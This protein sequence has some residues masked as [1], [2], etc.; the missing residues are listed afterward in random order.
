MGTIKILH[1]L[2]RSLHLSITLLVMGGCVQLG[3]PVISE[4]SQAAKPPRPSNQ[5]VLRPT[6][7]TK[8]PPVITQ[9]PSVIPKVV[10]PAAQP[11]PKAARTAPATTT[12]TVGAG[13]TLY[14]IAW[15]FQL[16][17]RS[18]AQANNIPPPYTIYPGQTLSLTAAPRTPWQRTDQKAD[19]KT[20]QKTDQKLIEQARTT[21]VPKPV[22]EP[23]PVTALPPGPGAAATGG[24]T[25]KPQVGP[26]LWP[27][28]TRPT[29][30]FSRASKGM[31]FTLNGRTPVR[32]ASSGEVVY[33]GSGIGG[34]ER[35]VIVKHNQN[36][37]SAYSLNGEIMVREQQQVKAGAKLADIRNTGRASQVL[38]FELRRN[39]QPINPREKLP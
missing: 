27:V 23:E 35:L 29:R 32:A 19:H 18:L 25:G 15:R 24:V 2:S 36:L 26:W 38:H 8:P 20:V 6:R 30:E 11:A 39:G 12:Y 22:A 33:A 31:D 13:E 17:H 37:L 14:A 21:A 28:N 5:G 16:D 4:Q 10:A 9:T 1:K 7:N 34:Y 3:Q